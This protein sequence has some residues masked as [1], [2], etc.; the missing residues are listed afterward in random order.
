[1]GEVYGYRWW[2]LVINS[3]LAGYRLHSLSS[4]FIPYA[5]QQE[6]GLYGANN[7]PWTDGRMEAVCTRSSMRMFM[8]SR[9]SDYL[10][11]PP[12]T[13]EACGCGFWAYFNKDV[14][15]ADIIPRMGGELPNL[16]SYGVAIPVFGVIKGT[17]R[18]IIGD[19]GFRS[20]YAQ[21]MGLCLSPAAITQLSWWPI[22]CERE[23]FEAA[24][25]NP[26]A[27]KFLAEKCSEAEHATRIS[28]IESILCQC[29]PSA[30]LFTSQELLTRY[31]PPDKNYA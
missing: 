17:G 26:L 20:Q 14:R 13:R 23:G 19:K 2:Y 11:F 28:V 5:A 27:E 16:F 12:E 1:M 24:E 30:R 9:P 29:F 18:I 4:T 10:H 25:L 3:E 7:K 22:M 6:G 8:F 31:F 15:V 21:I